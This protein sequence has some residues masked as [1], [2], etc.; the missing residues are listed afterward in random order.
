[1]IVTYDII[2]TFYGITSIIVLVITSLWRW[3]NNSLSTKNPPNVGLEPTTFRYPSNSGRLLR[4]WRSTDWASRDWLRCTAFE[5]CIWKSLFEWKPVKKTPNV[6]LEPTTFR[7]LLVPEETQLRVWRSTDWAS[8][9]FGWKCGGLVYSY[10]YTSVVSST[11]RETPDVG[12]E[13]TTFRLTL[14]PEETLVKV[15]RS[16]NWASRDRTLLH[17]GGIWYLR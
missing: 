12:L 16:T 9:D 5:H 17:L 11:K 2:G 4:V 8:R 3:K 13:P 7:L 1:M 14:V 6:G 15:W 10:F